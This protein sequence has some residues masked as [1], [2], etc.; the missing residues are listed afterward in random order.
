MCITSIID[1]QLWGYTVE[2][3]LLL[4]V[5]EQ[6]KKFQYQWFRGETSYQI[7]VSETSG[8]RCP[9]RGEAEQSGHHDHLTSAALA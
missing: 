8:T 3:K 2:E 9:L 7:W 1:Q 6:K 4:V 5:R